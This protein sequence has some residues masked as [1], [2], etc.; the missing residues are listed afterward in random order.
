MEVN[1]ALGGIGLEVGCDRPQSEAGSER[2]A[3]RSGESV[4]GPRCEIGF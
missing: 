1:G 3:M 2:L 4:W